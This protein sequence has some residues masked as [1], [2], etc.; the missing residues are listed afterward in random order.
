[1]M[2]E[3]GFRCCATGFESGDDILLKNMWK[4]Q[5]VEAQKKFIENCR[6]LGILVHGCF[7]V[8][9]PGETPE[10]MQKTLNLAIHLSPD[11]AQFYPVMPFPGTTYYIWAKEKG[12]LATDRFSEWLNHEGG[13]RCVLN[14][15]GLS[16]EIIEKFCEKA[17]RR[18]HFRPKYLLYKLKQAFKNKMEGIRSIRSF[19]WYVIY[20]FLNKRDKTI[21][22]AMQKI[23]VP[24][25]W[26]TV[27]SMP[28]GRMFEQ[29]TVLLSELKDKKEEEKKDQLE[30]LSKRHPKL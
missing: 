6:K 16:P 20:L 24:S 25:N 2:K 21:P 27:H 12:Y 23:E 26:Y 19:F 7:M 8:G 1:L 3:A 30:K 4:G 9:F 29:S 15:P 17:Y 13:H 14:L 10:T 11:S 28:K 5:T 18:F 22:F